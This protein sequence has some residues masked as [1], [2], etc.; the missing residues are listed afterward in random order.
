MFLVLIAFNNDIYEKFDVLDYTD[1]KGKLT[2]KA[3]KLNPKR[4]EILFFIE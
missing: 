1:Y 3:C 2:Q 4:R